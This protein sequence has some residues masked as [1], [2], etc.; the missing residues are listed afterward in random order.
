MVSQSDLRHG[1][2]DAAPEGTATQ[3]A[4][5]HD[6]APVDPKSLERSLRPFGEGRMLPREAYTSEA[7]MAWEQRHFFEG[8]WTCIGRGS[9]VAEPGDQRAEAVGRGGVFVIRG[10]DGVVRAFANACR[11]RGHELLPCGEDTVNR[12]IVLCPYHAWSYRLDGRLR[13]APGFDDVTGFNLDEFGLVELPSVEWQGLVFVDTSGSAGDFAE[14]VAGLDGI[15]GPYELERLVTR[16][17]HVYEVASNWKV[18][19]ENYEECY[20]CPVIHP[21]LCAASPPRSGENYHHPAGAWVGGWMDIR[22]GYATMSLDGHTGAAPLRALDERRRRIVD[23][24]AIFPNLLLSLHPDYVMSHVLTPVAADRT[25]VVCEW[26]F[27]PEDAARDDF[28]P[29]FAVSF[30]DVT[31]RQDWRACESVQRGLSNPR[32]LP[33]PMSPEEDGVHQ[34]VSMVAAAYAGATTRPA[35]A[36]SCGV[37]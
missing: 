31:N 7:V 16:G 2:Q 15:V 37:G 1:E 35:L 19:I 13:K 14:H 29:S 26:Y 10:H 18:L 12:P 30:W 4:V 36:A 28:D 11:H 22:E 17:R 23:Y 25:R 9:M 5:S 33:G 20:H 27:A 6:T 8:G 24:I 21:E 34:F 32:A 3:G